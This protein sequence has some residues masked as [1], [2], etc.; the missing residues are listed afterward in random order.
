MA[1]RRTSANWL[2]DDMARAL[3]AT[4]P[5]LQT[6][7]VRHAA[8]SLTE[9]AAASGVVVVDRMFRFDADNVSLRNVLEVLHV[10]HDRHAGEPGRA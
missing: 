5:P 3:A 6:A 4:C 7:D 9:H 2:S 10:L 1:S 8:D